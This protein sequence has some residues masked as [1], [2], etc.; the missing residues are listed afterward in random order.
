MRARHRRHLTA[1]HAAVI[2]VYVT[3]YGA[4]FG[5]G[6]AALTGDQTPSAAAMFGTSLV[7]LLG[8]RR[9]FR[10]AAHTVSRATADNA[11][12]HHDQAAAQAHHHCDAR[13]HDVGREHDQRH[14]AVPT[15][16]DTR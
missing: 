6:T 3:A 13:C 2:A 14:P 4:A 5:A 16:K 10:H 12:D 1:T 8:I 15:R 9:E 11:V 7:L